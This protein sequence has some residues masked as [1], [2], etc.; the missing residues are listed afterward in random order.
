MEPLL[1]ATHLAGRAF[2]PETPPQNRRG[3]LHAQS[4][5]AL[6]T[7]PCNRN[8]VL[9]YDLSDSNSVT[10]WEER[11]HLP[12]PL[13][14][15]SQLSGPAG[16]EHRVVLIR[17][18]SWVL[19]PNLVFSSPVTPGP[20]PAYASELWQ[21]LTHSAPSL[22]VSGKPGLQPSHPL[23]LDSCFCDELYLHAV[24]GNEFLWREGQDFFL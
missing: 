17:P 10:P 12:A 8:T 4:A 23:G 5:A 19:E 20:G 14:S 2:W 13:S 1:P 21:G 7:A 16:P 6:P 11:E 9:A 15:L 22:S 24:K 18:S 3:D